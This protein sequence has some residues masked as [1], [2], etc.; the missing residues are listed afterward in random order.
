MIGPPGTYISGKIIFQNDLKCDVF[1]L[2]STSLNSILFDWRLQFKNSL[3]VSRIPGL[4]KYCKSPFLHVCRISYKI[5]YSWQLCFLK[6]SNL[7]QPATVAAKKEKFPIICSNLA[8]CDSCC[9]LQLVWTR[10][11]VKRPW[12]CETLI[13]WTFAVPL[14]KYYCTVGL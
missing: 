14:G 4:M 1:C 3:V 10:L 12:K 9:Y 7:M 6:A 8:L 11:K 13:L 2:V 5:C